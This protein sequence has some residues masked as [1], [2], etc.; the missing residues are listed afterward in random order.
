MIDLNKKKYLKKQK[1]EKG[2]TYYSLKKSHQRK[3][4][5]F[6][7]ILKEISTPV[8]VTGKKSKSISSKA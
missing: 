7:V 1:S 4:I 2:L 3:V 8:I 5:R 6:E